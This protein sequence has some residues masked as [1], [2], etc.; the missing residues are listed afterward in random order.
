MHPIFPEA[1]PSNI[2]VIIR[3]NHAEV[4]VGISVRETCSEP[5][6]LKEILAHWINHILHTGIDANH[7]IKAVIIRQI[8]Q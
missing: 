3:I 5:Y 4:G 8:I 2:L 7:I 6:T 1:A